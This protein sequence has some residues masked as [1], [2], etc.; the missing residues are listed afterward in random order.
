MLPLN[1]IKVKAGE[2]GEA[3]PHLAI[4]IVEG[5]ELRSTRRRAAKAVYHFAVRGC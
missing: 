5:E 2:R 1:V 4:E 3:S